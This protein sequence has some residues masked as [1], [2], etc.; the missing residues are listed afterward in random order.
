MANT[1]SPQTHS[2]PRS[3]ILHIAPGVIVGAVYFLI[4]APLV[5]AGFPS[6]LAL[7]LAVPVGLIPVQLGFLFREGRRRTGR[8]T[9]QGVVGYR[10]RLQWWEYVVW[11][12]GVFV[13][14]GAVFTFMKPVDA[15]LRE[16]LF[17]WMP[18]VDAG[19]D[20]GFTAGKLTITYVAV[21]LFGAVGG[22]VV[23]ELYFRGY[24]LPRTPGRLSLLWHSLMFAAY[25][26]FTPWMIVTRTIGMLPLAFAVRRKS[27]FIG[28]IVHVAVN[29][30]DVVLGFAHIAGM[31]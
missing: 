22:P 26:V 17:F 20:G 21:L 11:S 28:I 25:H 9:L 5:N 19:L 23:E 31:G 18:S 8:M 6:I 3:M 24:L 7:M 15:F 1:H 27:L 29:S 30:I 2:V 12:L 10:N 13:V 16:Q 14:V 4:R